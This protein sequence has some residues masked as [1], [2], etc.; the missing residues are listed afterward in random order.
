MTAG[1]LFATSVIWA[2][3]E[4]AGPAVHSQFSGSR[5]GRVHLVHDFTYETSNGDRLDSHPRAGNVASLGRR[6][7][8]TRKSLKRFEILSH[9][10]FENLDRS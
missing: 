8:G 4:A 7:F 3:R 5:R 1:S 9:M 6:F 10:Q 2:P